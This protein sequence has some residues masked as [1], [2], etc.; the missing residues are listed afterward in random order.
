M[1]MTNQVTAIDA[2]A[3]VDRAIEALEQAN[4]AGLHLSKTDIINLE[5][6]FLDRCAA[7]GL[8]TALLERIHVLLQ[9]EEARIDAGDRESLNRRAALE[10]AYARFLAGPDARAH[11]CV[12]A[13]E[14]R[15]ASTSTAIC[16]SY[17]PPMESPED[18]AGARS[19]NSGAA[20]TS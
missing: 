5:R 2:L 13:A 1:V 6:D 8:P 4:A 16:P 11:G 17:E 12:N 3:M 20:L 18:A 10:D 15:P 9:R 14:N 19:T 7:G